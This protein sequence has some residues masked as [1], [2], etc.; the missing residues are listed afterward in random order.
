MFG[1]FLKNAVNAPAG[2]PSLR[3]EKKRRAAPGMNAA[4]EQPWG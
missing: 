1:A 3:R 2:V 4:I